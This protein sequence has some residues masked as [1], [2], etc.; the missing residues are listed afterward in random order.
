[1]TIS[2]GNTITSHLEEARFFLEP[3]NPLHRQ[4]EALRAYFV[5]GLPSAEAAQRFGYTPGAFRVLCHQFRHGQNWQERF[6]REVQH[7]PQA[8]PARDPVREQVV[9][10]RKKNLSVYDIRHELKAQGHEISIN[11]L[12]VLLREEGFARLPRRRD[13]ERPAS[14]KPEPAEVADVRK[15]DLSPRSFR[16]RFAG[17][18]LL[19]PLMKHLDLAQVAQQAKLPGTQMIPAEQALRSLLVLKLIGKERK[20][21]V[22]NLVFDEGLALFAGL[23]VIPKRSYLAAYSSRIGERGIQRFMQTW[24]QQVQRIGLARSGSLDL[25]F[26]TV[27][28]NS[29][30]E[31]L[32]KH[33][34]SKRSRS[35]KGVLVFLARDAEQRVMC[36]ANAHIP[37]SEQA[38]E[39]LHFVQFWQQQTGQV[40][41]ELVFDSR[42]TTYANLRKLDNLN[43]RFLTLRRR[44]RTLLAELYAR[45]RSAWRRVTLRSLTR[46]YRTPRVFD[47]RVKI[48]D[49]GDKPIRQLSILD[50]GHEDPTL[51]LTN[52]MQATPATLITRYAQRMLIENGIAEAIHFF[53]IDSLSSMVGLKVDFDLQLTLAASSLYRLFARHLPENY[54]HATAKMLFDSLLDVGGK[55]EIEDHHVIVTLDKRAHNPYLVDSGL[56]DQPTPMPWLEGKQLIIQFA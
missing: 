37:K 7:G 2:T 56:A 22:M 51:L 19:V 3:V 32:Q 35:Q 36:Y 24:F 9:A 53:H 20:S 18:F 4:Y 42:L 48:R 40:P 27:P 52:D 54:H 13:E 33:Y 5:E 10:L 39:I 55:I 14:I 23:N 16:T 49:Y 29:D 45:P 50:L 12:S 46:I 31:P 11:S 26:H 44:T 28:A 1:V 38:D 21:H 41:Q 34:V 17:L 47:E 30:K 25:D 6:F 15:L 8:A 43:I